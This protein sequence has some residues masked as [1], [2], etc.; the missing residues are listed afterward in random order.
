[1]SKCRAM[2]IAYADGTFLG[3]NSMK[4]HVPASGRDRDGG[5]SGYLEIVI[6]SITA[7]VAGAVDPGAFGFA[8]FS[9][10]TDA[11]PILE[12]YDTV[13]AGAYSTIHMTFPNG[14]PCG[15][16][17]L[18]VGPSVAASSTC[19]KLSR[20]KDIASGGSTIA[21]DINACPAVQFIDYT[22]AAN[23]SLTVTYGYAHQAELQP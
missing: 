9:V 23:F 12:A 1:M 18:D 21:Q 5:G 8:L 10:N 15:R 4:L 13:A 19:L 20:Q 7:T 17:A 16:Q 11:A 2:Q 6:Y 22:G 3:S 14:L